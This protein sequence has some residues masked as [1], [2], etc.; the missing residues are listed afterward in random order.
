MEEEILYKIQVEGSGQAITSIDN[1]TKANK[2]LR[3]ERKKL[4]LDS[5]AG[6]ARAQA[7]NTQLDQNTELIK[8]NSSA[9]EQQRMN[10]G[11]YKGALDKLIPGFGATADGIS[12]MTATAKAFIATP[13]GLILAAVAAAIGVV[14]AAFKKSEPV[15]DF[16]ENIITQSTAAIDTFLTNIDKVASI[17]GNLITGNIAAA[18]TQFGEL[19]GEISSATTMAQ[20][21]LDALRDLEDAQNLFTVSSASTESQIKALIIASKN[22]NLTFEEQEEKIKEAL[23]L[24]KELTDQRIELARREEVA[25][26]KQIALSEGTRQSDKETFDQFVDRLLK[27]EELND[28]QK[29]QV[30]ELSAARIKA[31]DENLAFQEKA[32]NMLTAISDKRIA[33]HEKETAAIE[34]RIEAGQKLIEEQF[35][36]EQERYKKLVELDDQRRAKREEVTELEKENAQIEQE[37]KEEVYITDWKAYKKAE[38]EKSKISFLESQN[39]LDVAASTLGAA[40]ALFRENTLAYKAL[41]IGQAIIDTYRAASAA[42]APPPVGAGP[43]FGPILAG[44]TIGLG[45]ANVARITGVQMGF[46]RGGR[47]L[48]GTRINHGHGHSIYRDNG[49]NLLATVK[50]GEVILNERQQA[51][52]GGAN[53]FKRIGVPGFAGGGSVPSFSTSTIARQ[54]ES[55]SLSREVL[56]AI[57]QIKP[58]VTVEDINVGQSRVQVVETGSQVL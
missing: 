45:L 49:D 39:R 23:R 46:A 34:K 18:A 57:T 27:G 22:R 6:K 30:A 2:A 16:F 54:S 40:K 55:I 17:L 43:L 9:L 7:I 5:E 20:L 26:I 12:G 3:E 36:Q 35:K 42:I 33:A 28:E 11:N 52:L 47:V 38:E 44:T 14:V 4:D 13:L 15:L 25:T 53:T 19:A 32:A 1:L 31:E 41:A 56:S 10:V 21:Y 8:K 50:T 58:I 37:E 24:E 29:K 51:M 48:S